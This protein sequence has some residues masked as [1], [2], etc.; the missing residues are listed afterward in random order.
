MGYNNNYAGMHMIWHKHYAPYDDLAYYDRL[1]SEKNRKVKDIP[2]KKKETKESNSTLQLETDKAMQIYKPKI[3]SIETIYDEACSQIDK[4]YNSLYISAIR[5]HYNLEAKTNEISEYLKNQSKDG[6]IDDLLF[7]S[8]ASRSIGANIGQLATISDD[9]IK[10]VIYRVVLPEIQSY[11]FH[12]CKHEED[13]DYIECNFLITDFS[14]ESAIRRHYMNLRLAVDANKVDLLPNISAYYKA[15]I[16]RINSSKEYS[17]SISIYSSEYDNYLNYYE[18]NVYKEK[19]G[20]I[21]DFFEKNY[22]E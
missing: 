15:T 22:K 12:H 3:K 18:A 13:R 9:D 19:E 1:V 16:Y 7:L 4:I 11:E 10:E 20:E 21:A 8:M 2:K 5:N 6:S 14:D 17:V